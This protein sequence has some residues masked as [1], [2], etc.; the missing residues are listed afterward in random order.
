MSRA[1]H[2]V[3]VLTERE[4]TTNTLNNIF[5][6]IRVILVVKKSLLDPAITTVIAIIKA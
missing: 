4:N 6:T 1:E 2:F 5:Q 3:Q